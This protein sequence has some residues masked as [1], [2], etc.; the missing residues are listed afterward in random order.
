MDWRTNFQNKF[1]MHNKH[2]NRGLWNRS[3]INYAMG[4][5]DLGNSLNIRCQSDAVTDTV[6]GGLMT[7]ISIITAL[8]AYLT[9]ILEHT[10]ESLYDDQ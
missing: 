2:T 10:C 8:S 1:K 6:R 3:S 7:S 5:W 9:R 4:L